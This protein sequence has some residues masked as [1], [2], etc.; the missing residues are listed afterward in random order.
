MLTRKHPPRPVKTVEH[1]TLA[2]RPIAPR[3]GLLA[4]ALAL[5]G[6]Q[7]VRERVTASPAEKAHMGRVKLLRCVLCRRLGQ[8]QDGITDVH[9]LRVEQGGAQRASNWL[10]AALGHNCCHQGKHGIH[11]DRARLRQAK[12]TE[13]DLLAW[14]LED[15]HLQPEA[16]GG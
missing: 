6:A 1:V 13:I 4:L 10:V 14:T 16:H 9:H 2:P 7:P 5:P 3:V 11:G 12:C 8:Q 15:L